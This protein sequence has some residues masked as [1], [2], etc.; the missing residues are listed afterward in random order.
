MAMKRFHGWRG[1]TLGACLCV[2][3]LV[4]AGAQPSPGNA[5]AGYA[6]ASFFCTECHVIIREDRAGWTDAP[7][8]AAIADRPTT[9]AAWLK[10]FLQQ[11]HM[12]M[13]N[14]PRSPADAGDIA[15][16]ILS[17]KGK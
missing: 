3:P 5:R 10:G 12:H 15:A 7:S 6:L 11:P 13:L 8:F 16:Y 1:L 17:L 14:L 4:P 9:T 2:L